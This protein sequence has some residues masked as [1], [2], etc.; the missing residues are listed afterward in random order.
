MA[1]T[2]VLNQANVTP[3]SAPPA[4]YFPSSAGF[5]IPAGHKSWRMDIDQTHIPADATYAFDVEYQR[6]G[7]WGIDTG[8]VF[9]GGPIS[10]DDGTSNTTFINHVSSSIGS[11]GQNGA[12]IGVYP[13]RARI[14]VKSYGSW[15]LPSLSLTLSTTL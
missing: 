6:N 2:T 1:T 5:P 12:L 11:Y 4:Y 15:L 8:A 10:L 7:V 14:H 13:S 3:P 9:S